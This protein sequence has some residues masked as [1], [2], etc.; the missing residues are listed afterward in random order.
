VAERLVA[1]QEG[2]SSMELF[3]TGAQ[4]QFISCKVYILSNMRVIENHELECVRK[5]CYLTEE[6]ITKIGP[7]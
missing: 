1:S 7:V 3:G 4:R 5:E 6:K 2:L